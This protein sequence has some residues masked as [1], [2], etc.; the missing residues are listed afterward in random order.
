MRETGN[1]RQRLL[2]TAQVAEILGRSR[3]VI[4]K[5]TRM[6][7][8]RATVTP[9]ATKQSR[10]YTVEEVMRFTQGAVKENGCCSRCAC[11][12]RRANPGPLCAP[13]KNPEGTKGGPD[14]SDVMR[15]QFA[16][17]SLRERSSGTLVRL[18]RA[19]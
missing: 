10:W 1:D 4:N 16:R 3:W 15:G 2:S 17:A 8:L 5:M 11:I 14:Y 9:K 7:E 18:R 12:L 19:S 6:G 13:C